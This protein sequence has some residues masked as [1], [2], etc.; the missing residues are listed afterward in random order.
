[1][2]RTRWVLSA[3]E[4]IEHLARAEQL[5]A[6]GL[7]IA[8]PIRP[9]LVPV[10]DFEI[11]Y[12]P[13]FHNV[14]LNIP[15][16]IVLATGARIVARRPILLEGNVD[17]RLPWNGPEFELL[18]PDANRPYRLVSELTFDREDVLNQRLQE[19]IRLQRGD[20]LEGMLL[21][22]AYQAQ[23]PEEYCH[24]T[25]IGVR[26]ALWD[27]LGAEIAAQGTVR[28]NRRMEAAPRLTPPKERL[29]G[30]SSA[31]YTHNHGANPAAQILPQGPLA[32]SIAGV[33]SDPEGNTAKV[34]KQ[35]QEGLP[36][37]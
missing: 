17:V 20:V 24:G 16:R 30:K 7:D 4:Q 35:V 26:I 29:F 10:A 27:S 9:S 32:C 1:M 28:V 21:L 34:S 8:V 22:V 11:E 15:G 13:E 2:S 23:L 3:R 12:A 6:M 31:L 19:G 25:P 36:I 18:Y 14:I 33:S 37:Q 5:R